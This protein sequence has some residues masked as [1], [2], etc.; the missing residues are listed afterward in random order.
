M[1]ARLPRGRAASIRRRLSERDLALLRSLHHLRLLT[2]RQAQRLHVAD[3]SPIT[4]IRRTQALLKRL[5]RHGVVVRFGRVIGGIRAGS[6]GYIYGLSGLGQAILGVPGPGGKR[7][8]PVW[9]TKPYF[10]DHILAVADV[11]VHLVEAWRA[12]LHHLA[13]FEPEPHAWR[14]FAGPGGQRVVLKPDAFAYVT[15]ARFEHFLFVEVDLN[16]ESPE[17]ISRKCLRYIAYWRTG[18]EQGLRGIFPKVVWLVPDEQRRA[19]ISSV[20]GELATETQVLFTTRLLSE[21]ANL[22][23]MLETEDAV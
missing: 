10:Q 6:S 23:A 7:R 5:H 20:I 19:K 11:F 22:A 15:T 4:Q 14:I 3:G 18:I 13:A 9:N 17:T 16:S 21:V 2:V 1:T 12:Q 8:R